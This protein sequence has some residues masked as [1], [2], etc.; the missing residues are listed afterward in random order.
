MVRNILYLTLFNLG[1]PVIIFV[2]TP[3]ISRVY[4]PESIGEYYYILTVATLL[5]LVITGC[6]FNG[7]YAEKSYRR[8]QQVFRECV[9]ISISLSLML[10]L[11]LLC[12]ITILLILG[13]PTPALDYILLTP[14]AL[15]LALTQTG[16]SLL[17]RLQLYDLSGKLSIFRALV[18]VSVQLAFGTILSAT[19]TTL[20]LTTIACEILIFTLTARHAPSFIT[21]LSKKRHL[22]RVPK[23]YK[24]HLSFTKYFLPSQLISASA[25]TLP[26]VFLRVSENISLLGLFTMLLRLTMVPANAVGQSIRSTY[27]NWIRSH[28]KNPFNAG[29]ISSLTLHL[30]AAMLSIVYAHLSPHLL[31]A[32]LGH[33]WAGIDA[34]FPFV[35]LWVFSSLANVPLSESV[36]FGLSSR[37][38]LVAELFLATGKAAVL[39]LTQTIPPISSIQLFCIASWSIN[40]IISIALLIQLR[41]L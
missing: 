32:Y 17:S 24:Q 30:A 20:I 28:G 13:L 3:L 39:A 21:A 11:L 18:T 31:E 25:N 15:A 23:R 40:I 8:A 5:S 4:T 35:A 41:R 14:L 33:K 22:L 27:W 19:A 7:I 37:L 36:K 16:Y 2:S 29:L 12:A 38:L 10:Q 34:L 6:L 1:G 9:S 26:L